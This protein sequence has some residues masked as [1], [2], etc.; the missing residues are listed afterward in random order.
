[1]LDREFSRDTTAAWLERLRGSVPVAPVNDVGEALDDPF[2]SER[3]SVR[4]FEYP[5][6][7]TARLIAN[8]IRAGTQLPRRAAP[9]LGAD[10]DT[11]LGELGYDSERIAALRASKAVG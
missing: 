6:G 3:G 7:R 5:D 1:M 2:V 9:A 4:D 8:P 11:L 10:T